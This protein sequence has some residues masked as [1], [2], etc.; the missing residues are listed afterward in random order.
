MQGSNYLAFEY[1]VVD[2]EG[3][4]NA[5]RLKIS[6]GIRIELLMARGRS[7]QGSDR[8]FGVTTT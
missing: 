7:V 4:C 1:D 5:G 3:E 8:K 6:L 2:R